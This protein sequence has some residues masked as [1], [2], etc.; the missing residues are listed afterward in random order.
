MF[1]IADVARPA[2][3]KAIEDND[4][5]QKTSIFRVSKVSMCND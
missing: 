5:F 3:C 1:C 2:T 4:L